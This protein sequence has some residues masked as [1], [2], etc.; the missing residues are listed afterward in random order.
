MTRL[1]FGMSASSFAAN[2][3]VMQNA[4]V[5]EHSHPQAALAVCNSFYVDDSLMGVDSLSEATTFRKELQDM[6]DKGGFLLRKWKSNVPAA[7]RH[8]PPHL[9][10]A[11]PYH[12]LPMDNESVIDFS[13]S[14]SRSLVSTAIPSW[15]RCTSL[16]ASSPQSACSLRG[17][18]L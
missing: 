15:T 17:C 6:F 7:L 9:V 5:H 2:M 18:S 16:Q 12:D 11:K 3:V 13:Q 10:D 8:L 4:I 1:T 14:L